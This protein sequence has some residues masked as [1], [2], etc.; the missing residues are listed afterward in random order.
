MTVK[1][2]GELEYGSDG[3]KVVA[4]LIGDGNWE[5]RV[6]GGSGETRISRMSANL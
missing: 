5:L 4:E 2:T 1:E 3:G 6:E